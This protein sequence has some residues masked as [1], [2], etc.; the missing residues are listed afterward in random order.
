MS[1]ASQ[2]VAL[3]DVQDCT[4]LAVDEQT[5]TLW[6]AD[7]TGGCLHRRALDGTRSVLRLGSK[8][9][10][11][12]A[13]GCACDA[14]G[15]IVVADA[16]HCIRVFSPSGDAV[17]RYG[18]FQPGTKS[19]PAFLAT[20]TSPSAVACDNGAIAFTDPRNNLIRRVTA[21]GLVETVAGSEGKAGLR[22][23][24]GPDAL[25]NDPM[26]LAAGPGVI[27]VADSNN[28]CIRKIVPAGS[29]RALCV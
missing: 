12:T 1:V 7:R 10:P 23:G 28:N 27:F 14:A 4:G 11:Y 25:F 15:N 3:D 20:L 21:D 26:G 17:A 9:A 16:L 19:G 5:G 29:L 13:D 8:V 18:T 22:N 2:F 24:S 6:V